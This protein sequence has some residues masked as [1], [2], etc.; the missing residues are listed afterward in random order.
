MDRKVDA[1]FEMLPP[2]ARN[3]LKTQIMQFQ[4]FL[5]ATKTFVKLVQHWKVSQLSALYTENSMISQKLLSL[6][7]YKIIWLFTMAMQVFLGDFA[8]TMNSKV[9]MQ[10]ERA[11]YENNSYSLLE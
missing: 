1:V 11:K 3:F 8:L 10:V 5:I 4:L 7:E 9:A 2:P 6:H